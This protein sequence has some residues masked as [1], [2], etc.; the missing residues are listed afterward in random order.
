MC[1]GYGNRR[2]EESR[3]AYERNRIEFHSFLANW[4]INIAGKTT[5]TSRNGRGSKEFSGR[6]GRFKKS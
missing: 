6:K 5:G 1:A 3:K 2:T 4:K